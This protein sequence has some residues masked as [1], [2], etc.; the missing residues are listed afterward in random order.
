[1]E[2]TLNGPLWELVGLGSY[3]IITIA[4]HGQSFGNG[5]GRLQKLYRLHNN[6]PSYTLGLTKH[7][8]IDWSHAM[9]LVGA[10]VRLN[11]LGVG[12]VADT[13]QVLVEAVQ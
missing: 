2:L 4:L 3:N 8:K 13:V 5:G 1:M 12:L 7:S 10:A 9:Y 11:G 6:V